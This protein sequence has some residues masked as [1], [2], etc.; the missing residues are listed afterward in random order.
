[1]GYGAVEGVR[2]ACARRFAFAHGSRAWQLRTD[3]TD[4]SAK[5][6]LVLRRSCEAR[7]LKDAP[8]R[9][10][11]RLLEHPSRPVAC[12]NER[13]TRKFQSPGTAGAFVRSGSAARRGGLRGR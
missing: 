12:G 8:E 2:A 5:H 6:P 13:L 3:R 4:V 10:N 1:M 9:A 7:G 11:R